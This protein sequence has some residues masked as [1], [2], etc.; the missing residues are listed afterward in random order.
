VVKILADSTFDW[1]G[2]A[3]FDTLRQI[4]FWVMNADTLSAISGEVKDTRPEA[5]GSIYLFARQL[6]AG[7]KSQFGFQP[8]TP[9]AEGTYMVILPEPGPYLFEHILPGAY[10]LSAFRDANR[11][12]RYDFGAVSPYISAERFMMWPDTIKV[13]SRWP[14]EGN[15]FVLP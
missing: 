12:G 14:N 7:A 3:V 5:T 4:T 6:G 8:E 11:N 13:R 15:E 1:N 10:Q 2:N 9:R